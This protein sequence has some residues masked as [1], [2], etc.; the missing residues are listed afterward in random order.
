MVQ[1]GRRTEATVDLLNLTLG[2]LLFLSPWTLGFVSN[3][4]SGNAW[5][6]GALISLA[7]TAAIIASDTREE[8]FNLLMGLW[9]AGSPWLLGLHAETH[10]H[11]I[12]GVTVATLA[13]VELWLT[14]RTGH[15]GSR[16]RPHYSAKLE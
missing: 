5:I 15:D 13:C 11:F 4:A 9:V 12:V 7:A 2:M 10:I 1:K 3:I 8:R 6:S 16:L 14:R